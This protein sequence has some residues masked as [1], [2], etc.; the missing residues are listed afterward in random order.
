VASGARLFDLDGTLWD[1]FTF[2]ASV[3][4]ESGAITAQAAREALAG[5]ENVMKLVDRLGVP[6]R[7]LVTALGRSTTLAPHGGLDDAIAH[8][9]ARGH[10]LGVVTNLSGTLA[11]PILER[12][13][14]DRYF[15]VLVHAGSGAGRKPDPRPI[16]VA[17]ERLGAQPGPAHI[18]VGDHHG[19]QTAADSAGIRFAWA[20]WGYGAPRPDATLLNAPEDLLAL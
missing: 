3:A 8:L 16:L 19:D 20:G 15:A 11:V 17:L 6:R 12:L 5:G 2:Y 18:Y 14:L 4:A 1:S 7:A 13:N 10:P 9:A